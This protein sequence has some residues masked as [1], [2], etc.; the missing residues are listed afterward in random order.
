VVDTVLTDDSGALAKTGWG[1]GA[2]GNNGEW[3]WPASD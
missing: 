3:L 1:G 2:S